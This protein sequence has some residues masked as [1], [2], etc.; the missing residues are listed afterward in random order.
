MGSQF[1]ICSSKLTLDCSS[2]PKCLHFVTGI[3]GS[4]Y[5]QTESLCGEIKAYIHV[6]LHSWLCATSNFFSCVMCHNQ[7]WAILKAALVSSFESLCVSL[8]SVCPCLTISHMLSQ[9]KSPPH[10]FKMSALSDP[11]LS[12]NPS[13]YKSIICLSAIFG[14][15]FMH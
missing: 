5:H 4:L 10:D 9:R 12:V 8:L 1:V 14:S 15:F 3:S 2:L 6:A 13:N 11:T 7:R